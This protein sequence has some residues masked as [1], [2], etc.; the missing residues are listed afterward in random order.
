[1]IIYNIPSL[2]MLKS[3]GELNQQDEE[4]L[5]LMSG[6]VLGEEIILDMI[7]SVKLAYSSIGG[8]RAD[9]DDNLKKLVLLDDYGFALYAVFH[10]HPSDGLRS[11][12]QSPIDEKF[13]ETMERGGYK[14]ILGIFSRDGFLRFYRTKDDFKIKII[15]KGLEVIDEK[16]K[17]YK[18]TKTADVRRLECQ[19]A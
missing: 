12:H 11:S 9:P 13:Q 2:I 17:I 5:H 19:V 7:I 18:I 16:S 4:S 14:S 1:M 6:I 3:F 15:G 10:I 8:V